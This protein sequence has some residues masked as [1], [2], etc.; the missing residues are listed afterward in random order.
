M[1][2]VCEPQACEPLLLLCTSATRTQ[3]L[4]FCTH[5]CPCIQTC[6]FNLSAKCRWEPP[7]DKPDAKDPK[8]EKNRPALQSIHMD[9]APYLG[10]PAWC[11]HVCGGLAPEYACTVVRSN[12][13]PGACTVGQGYNFVNFYVGNG[14]PSHGTMFAPSLAWPICPD[15][16]RPEYARGP[17]ANGICGDLNLEPPP[18]PV[19]PP[20]AT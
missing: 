11:A 12:I 19:D 16:D 20:P 14:Q 8:L 1:C 17:K 10:A 5:Q 6:K 4:F 9:K 18:K 3:P 7:A 2:T 13:W 15:L